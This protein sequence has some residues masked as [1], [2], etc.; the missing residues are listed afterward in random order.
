[1]YH[2]GIR[3]F[4]L[5]WLVRQSCQCGQGSTMLA[6]TKDLLK[7]LLIFGREICVFCT[8]LSPSCGTGS[9]SSLHCGASSSHGNNTGTTDRPCNNIRRFISK[10]HI[11]YLIYNISYLIYHITYILSFTSMGSGMR[12]RQIQAFYLSL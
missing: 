5:G 7:Y 9:Y 11:S 12:Y 10:S 4:S 1:M 8:C 2:R 6:A 3:G